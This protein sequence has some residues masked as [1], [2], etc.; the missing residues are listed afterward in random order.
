MNRIG[1]SRLSAHSFSIMKPSQN[2]PRRK[3][4]TWAQDHLVEPLKGIISHAA[5]YP[6]HFVLGVGGVAL[7]SYGL[8]QISTKL[9]YFPSVDHDFPIKD[10]D[11]PYFDTYFNSID[12]GIKLHGWLIPS[13][14]NLN[15]INSNSEAGEIPTTPKPQDCG[16]NPLIFCHGNAGNISHR[17]HN[18]I[19]LHKYLDNTSV[20]IFDYRGYGHSNNNSKLGF[21]GQN[22]IIKD[23]KSAYYHIKSINNDSKPILFGRS[24]GGACVWHLFDQI[25]KEAIEN[26]QKLGMLIKK[27]SS[28]DDAKQECST[29][30]VGGIIIEN[31]FTNV[32]D[33][34]GNNF[35][36]FLGIVKD[37]WDNT[38]VIKDI[39]NQCLKK[40]ISDTLKNSIFQIP[41]LLVL[42][43]KDEVLDP[44]LMKLLHKQLIDAGFTNVTVKKF[45]NG[46]H[47]QTYTCTGYFDSL[48]SFTSTCVAD[49]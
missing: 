32:F 12:N 48:K 10:A 45:P 16:K 47:N 39:R 31:S 5:T 44:E 26:E 13:K 42:G 3:V 18:L 37:K 25:V 7:A 35:I 4:S 15:S 49:S 30:G 17:I 23:C 9:T 43:E 21:I 8:R 36:T 38:Q 41:I 40:D 2:S 29:I 27:D 6:Q 46:L 14:S 34:L 33:I 1:R 28:D 19:L 11:L 20:F 24:L 22:G